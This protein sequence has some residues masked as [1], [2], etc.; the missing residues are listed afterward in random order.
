M[1]FAFEGKRDVAKRFFFTK[2]ANQIDDEQRRNA[3]VAFGLCG[4]IVDRSDHGDVVQIRHEL[5]LRRRRNKEFDVP[6][7]VGGCLR[8]IL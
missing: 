5:A 7:A 2:I 8:K 6:D 4:R 1:I 3:K